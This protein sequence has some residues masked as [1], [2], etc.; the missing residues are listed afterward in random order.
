MDAVT[1]Y[2][3]IRSSCFLSIGAHRKSLNTG[4]NR[5]INKFD[6]AMNGER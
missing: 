2:D 3:N 4:A 1:M 5:L 6:T